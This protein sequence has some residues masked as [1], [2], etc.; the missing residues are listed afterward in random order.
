M[1]NITTFGDVIVVGARNNLN[2]IRLILAL[3][4][5]YSHSFQL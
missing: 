3:L 1:K 4:V 5:I 2:A